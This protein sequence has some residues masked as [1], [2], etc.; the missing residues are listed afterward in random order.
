MPLHHLIALALIQGITEFLPI[1]SSG[2]LAL[3]PLLTGAPDQGLEIDVAV[4]V[5]ALAAVVLYM[6]AEV[7]SAARGGFRLLRGDAA[8]EEPRLALLLAAATVPAVVAGGLLWALDLTDALRSLAVIGWA[9]LIG[10][11]LLELADRFG[12]RRKAAAEWGWRDAILMGLAQAVALIP[13]TSRSGATI[14][15]ARALGYGRVEAARL[16]ML[17]SIPTIL[18]AGTLLT[19]KLVR[20]GDAA[21]GLDAAI[22]AGLAFLSAFA[23]ILVFM[24]MLETWSMTVFTVYRVVL[25]VG[26][27]ALA[28]S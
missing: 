23:A 27:L 12:A 11:V 18:A 8:G 7:G 28:Y 25:G 4:H 20:D 1:S 10:G 21:L 5:G 15:A 24:K 26:L 13:G 19:L 3:Y 6:R 16:S 14:T 17:M 2:H 22:A 9:T